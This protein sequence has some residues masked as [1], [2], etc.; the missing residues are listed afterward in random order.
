VTTQGR[1]IAVAVL[2]EAQRMDD[3]KAAEVRTDLRAHQQE[4]AE[5][6]AIFAGLP[7]D[8]TL[9]QA[10]RIKA[11][12]GDA[13]AQK[14]VAYFDSRQYRLEKALFNAAMRKTPHLFKQHETGVIEWL[15]GGEGPTTG[16]VVEDFQKHYPKESR[17]I[18]AAIDAERSL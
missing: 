3:F 18:E 2:R 14:Y 10:C 7:A 1:D 4:D 16:A 13:V 6:R 15:G 5:V 17:A 9:E 11:A 12:T 8:T